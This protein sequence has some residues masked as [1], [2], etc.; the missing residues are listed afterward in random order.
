MLVGK[1]SLILGPV[2]DQILSVAPQLYSEKNEPWV[3]NAASAA[4]LRRDISIHLPFP[5]SLISNFSLSSRFCYPGNVLRMVRLI[6]YSLSGLD[7]GQQGII[8]TPFVTCMHTQTSI[9]QQLRLQSNHGGNRVLNVLFALIN[10][11]QST[12]SKGI[13]RVDFRFQRTIFSIRF[14]NFSFP[15]TVITAPTNHHRDL[16]F[17]AE[18]LRSFMKISTIHM[19]LDSFRT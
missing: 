2:C 7:T 12:C 10:L 5:H 14:G 16:V 15:Q 9:Y 4:A 1:C 8:F 13:P 17:G 3:H 11:P 18:I 6:V 19:L